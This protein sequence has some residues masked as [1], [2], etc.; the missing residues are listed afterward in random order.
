MVSAGVLLLVGVVQGKAAGL[1]T[2]KIFG[3]VG[4]AGIISAARRA[5]RGT[6]GM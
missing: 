2:M 4:D 3:E 5:P 1:G 6:G